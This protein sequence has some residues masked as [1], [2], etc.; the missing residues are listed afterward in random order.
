MCEFKNNKGNNINGILNDLY[1]YKP[2]TF[3]NELFKV[4]NLIFKNN[5]NVG[6]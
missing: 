2:F 4:R 3:S 6:N 1:N 5:R